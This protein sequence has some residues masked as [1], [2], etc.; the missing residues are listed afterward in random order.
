MSSREDRLLKT[1]QNW[2]L[3]LPKVSSFA[4]LRLAAIWQLAPLTKL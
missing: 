4:E 2:E 3:I 1:H